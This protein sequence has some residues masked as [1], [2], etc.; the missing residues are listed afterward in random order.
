[1]ITI[2]L[3]YFRTLAQEGGPRPR[4]R[5]KRK[6]IPPRRLLRRIIILQQKVISKDEESIKDVIMTKIY[7]NDLNHIISELNI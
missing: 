1:M 2:E 4:G 3:N 5:K 7:I 6:M